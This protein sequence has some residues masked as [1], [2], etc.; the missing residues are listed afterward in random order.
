[1]QRRGGCLGGLLQIFLLGWLFDWL[2]DTFG[3]GRNKSCAGCGCGFIL[4]LI[5]LY[6][7][8]MTLSGWRLPFLNF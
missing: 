6:L 8:I 5:F 3:W 7:L 1:M 4:L 2:Q